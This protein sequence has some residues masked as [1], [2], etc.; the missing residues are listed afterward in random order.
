MAFIV[1]HTGVFREK[2]QGV[3]LF[4]LL[5]SILTPIE[6]V[7]IISIFLILKNLVAW[8]VEVFCNNHKNLVDSPML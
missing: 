8:T 7:K 5:G 3:G 2:P 1:K 6:H 4:F